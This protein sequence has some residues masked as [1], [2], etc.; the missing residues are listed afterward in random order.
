MGRWQYKNTTNN[1]KTSMTPPEYR[2]SIPTIPEH[3]KA[4]DAVVNDL[5]NNFIKMTE[6]FKDDIRKSLK[7]MEEKINKKIGRNEQVS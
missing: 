7:E 1:R 2:A 6:S 5:K 3:P 4:N